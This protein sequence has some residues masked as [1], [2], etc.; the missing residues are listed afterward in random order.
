MS[1]SAGVEPEERYLPRLVAVIIMHKTAFLNRHKKIHRHQVGGGDKN[2]FW[3]KAMVSF[4]DKD[5]QH[6]A[7]VD[8]E[9]RNPGMK[10]GGYSGT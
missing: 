8:P 2:E 1:K 5:F 3:T 9:K 10:A 7:E 4:M 6:G